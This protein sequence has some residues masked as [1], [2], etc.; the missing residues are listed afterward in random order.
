M[1]AAPLYPNQ[2]A[3]RL[4]GRAYTSWSAITTYQGCGLRYFYRYVHRR[5]PPSDQAALRA[6]CA[7]DECEGKTDRMGG[8]SGWSKAAGFAVLV[9]LLRQPQ[10]LR[11]C[12]QIPNAAAPAS[13]NAMLQGSG[14]CTAIKSGSFMPELAKTEPAPFDPLRVSPEE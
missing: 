4:T 7:G 12:L 5:R 10:P 3:E 1:I 9:T 13:N 6:A 2:V 11:R 8:M 14:V